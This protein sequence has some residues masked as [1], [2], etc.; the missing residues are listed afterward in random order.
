MNASGGP[1]TLSEVSR[2]AD[3]E[4]ELLGQTVSEVGLELLWEVTHRGG[5]LGSWALLLSNEGHDT[6]ATKGDNRRVSREVLPLPLSRVGT[7]IVKELKCRPFPLTNSDKASLTATMRGPD[8]WQ[9]ACVLSLNALATNFE[10]PVLL[11]SPCRQFSAA[12][13]VSSAKGATPCAPQI[14]S[15]ERSPGL[16]V[17][18][19]PAVSR[20]RRLPTTVRWQWWLAG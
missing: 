5:E 8:I 10:A 12:P 6:P 16:Q 3:L 14:A 15:P 2:F 4:G 1:I 20:A 19:W 9:T 11:M 7:R 17:S 13:S 18:L